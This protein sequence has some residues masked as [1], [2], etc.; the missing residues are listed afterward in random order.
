MFLTTNYKDL[1]YEWILWI[2]IVAQSSNMMSHLSIMCSLELVFVV[3]L[4]LE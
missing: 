3:I 1:K 4:H 2:V